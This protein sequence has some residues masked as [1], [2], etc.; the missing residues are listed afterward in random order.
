[1]IGVG[2]ESLSSLNRAVCSEDFSL[3]SYSL[4]LYL[5]VDHKKYENHSMNTMV[6]LTHFVIKS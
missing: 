4:R 6:I 1:M 2:V 5:S 3:L